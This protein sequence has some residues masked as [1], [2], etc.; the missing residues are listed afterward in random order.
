MKAY[1]YAKFVMILNLLIS[2]LSRSNQSQTGSITSRMS[3]HLC[4]LCH[5]QTASQAV[6]VFFSVYL[7]HPPGFGLR[8]MDLPFLVLPVLN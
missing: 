3:Y 6:E 1:N 4:N 8:E 7:R 5:Y 2:T